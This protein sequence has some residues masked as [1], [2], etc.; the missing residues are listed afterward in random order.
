MKG[1]GGKALLVPT[2]CNAGGLRDKD[3]AIPK[4]QRG[5]VKKSC[6]G[7]TTGSRE[8]LSRHRP[9]QACPVT[10]PGVSLC[11]RGPP[12]HS[13]LDS[14]SRSTLTP[15][16]VLQWPAST[17]CLLPLTFFHLLPGKQN[18]TLLKP[19]QH[20]KAIILQFNMEEREV[21]QLCPA[22]CN[23]R[24]CNPLGSSIH[25]ILQARILEWVAISFSRGSS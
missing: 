16:R 9:E 19:P 25:E 18:T 3:F 7:G 12:L 13:L 23:P 15:R 21:A 8:H 6:C 2:P 11:P 5:E 14:S 22:L 20:C 1:T 4:G 17:N 10:P 24:D